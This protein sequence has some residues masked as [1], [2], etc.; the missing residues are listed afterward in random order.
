[1]GSAGDRVSRICP[2]CGEDRATFIGE[3]PLGF[4]YCFACKAEGPKVRLADAAYDAWE[5]QSEMR[6]VGGESTTE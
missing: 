2:E 5:S 4:F 3:G 6:D 1:M